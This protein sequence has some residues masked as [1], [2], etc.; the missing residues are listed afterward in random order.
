MGSHLA[1]DSIFEDAPVQHREGILDRAE[2]LGFEDWAKGSKSWGKSLNLMTF[3]RLA[4]RRG[5][6]YKEL[7][8][9]FATCSMPIASNL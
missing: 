1:L 9:G 7:T 8:Q 5:R 3:E 4:A 6:V 2:C